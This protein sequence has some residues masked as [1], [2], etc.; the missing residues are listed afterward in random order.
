MPASFGTQS[1]I[2]QALRLTTCRPCALPPAVWRCAAQSR[3]TRL[4]VSATGEEKDKETTA[5][6]T[7]NKKRAQ[8]LEVSLKKMVWRSRPS[9]TRL[10]NQRSCSNSAAML[11]YT[12]RTSLAEEH[13]G[14]HC[15]LH[16]AGH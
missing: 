3:L 8:E 1:T 4:R 5:V 13:A 6:T 14:Y 16:A 7:T 9:A 12:W 10:L 15:C 11:A 2:M